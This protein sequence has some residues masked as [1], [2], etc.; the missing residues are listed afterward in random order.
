MEKIFFDKHKNVKENR[1]EREVQSRYRN[2]K[3]KSSSVNHRSIICE[4]KSI[5]YMNAKTGTQKKEKKTE[6]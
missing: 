6:T 1:F 4:L 2:V 3:M 5:T